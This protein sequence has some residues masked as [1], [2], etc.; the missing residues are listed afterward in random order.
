MTTRKKIIITVTTVI[1]IGIGYKIF[2]AG[3]KDLITYETEVATMGSVEQTVSVTADLESKQ[4]VM[5]NFETVGRIKSINTYVGKKIAV[6]ETI[7]T[8]DDIAFE[9]DLRRADA[10]LA[11]ALANS[12]ASNDL[13]REAEQKKENAKDILEETE[14]L[15]DQRVDAAE[16]AYEDAKSNYE[17]AQEYYAQVLSDNG[18]G[19][20][21]TKSAKLTLNSANI[22]KHSA[23]EGVESAKKARDLSIVSAESSVKSAKEG[24]ETAESNY[25]K[26]SKDAAVESA[27]AT[28]QTAL[29]NLQK[30][31]LVSPI[32]GTVAQMNYKKGEVL[33]TSMNSVF[34][35]ILSSDFTLEADIP[36]SDIV[37]VKLEQ[38]ATVTFDAFEESEKFEAKVI[39]IEPA[40]TV[41]QDVVYY[42]VKLRLSDVDIR[43]REGMSGDV[44]IHTAEK[45]NVLVIPRRA[46][47]TEDD[48]QYV[49]ILIGDNEVK[50]V[51]VEA[52]LRGDDGEIEIVSGIS[53]G[54]KVI[55]FVNDPT[56]K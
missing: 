29:A 8:I 32:N 50:T 1:I 18:A 27:R 43:L 7:A 51:E 56:K 13:I 31:T 45:G 49:D 25:T 14:D 41:I 23:E 17:D 5:L 48:K 19:D 9:Q 16:R 30:A 44:D 24:I 34:G 3:K 10:A 39:E 15:E 52:G 2:F 38:N 55:V 46:L 40:A 47:R 53:S 11:Q 26:R 35:K 36:E 33:G 42:K 21:L 28:R 6:G 54:D 37:K 4:E 22:A 12:G 20:S